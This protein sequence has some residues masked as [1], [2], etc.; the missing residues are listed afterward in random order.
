MFYVNS[1]A[2]TKFS[3]KIP[4]DNL[5]EARINPIPYSKIYETDQNLNVAS[6]DSLVKLN[7]M[8]LAKQK[9]SQGFSQDFFWVQFKLDWTS[10]NQDLI[11]EVDNPHI[12]QIALYQK[13]GNQFTKI[14]FGG[15]RNLKFT[16]RSYVNR[17]YIF[18]FKNTGLLTTYY[19]MIDK[20]NASVSFPLWIW[21]SQHFESSEVKQN[22]YFGVFFGVIFF[23]GCIAL[24]VGVFVGKKVFL[25]YAGYTLSM[26]LYLFTA[27]GYS[28]QY[29]YPNSE[30]FNNYSRVILSVIIAIFTTLFLRVFLNIDQNSTKISRF[31]KII[32]SVLIVLTVAW[33]MFSGLYQVYTIWLLNVSNILFLSIFICAFYAAYLA[34]KTHRYN[35]IVFFMAFSTMILGIVAYLGIEYG[36]INEDIFPLNPIFL[37]SGFEII[38]LSFAMIFQ[39]T[40]IIKAKHTLEIKNLALQENTQSLE[41]KNQQLIEASLVLKKQTTV[42]K[43]ET[44]LLKS[45]AMLQLN[46]VTHISSD[47][48]YLEFYLTTKDNPEIDRNTIKSLLSQLPEKD[49]IQIHRSHIVNINFIKIIKAS[50]LVLMDGKILPV[51]RSYKTQIKQLI[52]S[53]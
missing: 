32:N 19:L 43:A 12:D 9:A 51:S 10:I 45:K 20:R 11:L 5:R 7:K 33:I 52:I 34:L 44:I 21:N 37:G 26:G 24:F 53:S 36:F 27:L 23:L 16:D 3:F 50:E 1:N 15:D 4:L 6:V 46:Q 13:K 8:S 35:A 39:L 22:I 31:Y 48:H 2:Q 38:I 29:L 49:F 30:N 17:R 28:F 14:G 41:A 25:Y 40:K 47:G 18:P 42:K